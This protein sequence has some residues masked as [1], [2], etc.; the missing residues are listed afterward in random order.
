MTEPVGS[1]SQ[2]LS[3]D[4]LQQALPGVLDSP[5]DQGILKKIFVRPGE[6][7]RH[8][9]E[10]ADV[11]PEG[12]IA[13]D[14]WVSD[15]WQHLADGRSDPESQITVMNSRILETIAGSEK[16]MCLAG[17]NL[18]VDLDLSENNFP[19][20]SQVHVGEGV[21]LEFTAE[22]H[23]GCNKFSARYGQQ[24]LKFV[25]GPLGKPQNLRG[26]YFRVVQG[27]TLQ[28]G[29]TVARVEGS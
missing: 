12:G 14:R 1:A 13:G 9:V 10:K 20:G 7:E 15:H 6:N 28:V 5:K 18:I 4:E 27:G 25:N 3:T 23:T 8:S 24:A 19:A 11:S 21:I 26:R 16:A 22:S 17:D 29:D 2:H